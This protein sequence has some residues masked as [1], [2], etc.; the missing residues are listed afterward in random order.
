MVCQLTTQSS[1][2]SILLGAKNWKPSDSERNSYP[3]TRVYLFLRPTSIFQRIP[4]HGSFNI[5]E[6]CYTKIWKWGR[7]ALSFCEA[8]QG[9]LWKGS[10]EGSKRSP[11]PQGASSSTAVV[12]HIYGLKVDDLKA[13]HP[14]ATPPTPNFQLCSP[15]VGNRARSW[16]MSL[17][18][19][20]WAV[21]WAGQPEDL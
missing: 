20:H 3:P 18:P 13:L 9:P 11:E 1:S 17:A 7:V 14:H 10:G 21:S 4:L 6:Q 15:W 19:G 2:P 16:A 12:L 5:P 8:G